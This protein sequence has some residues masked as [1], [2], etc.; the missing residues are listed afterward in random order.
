MKR[1]R[2]AVLSVAKHAY[3]PRGVASHPRFELVVVADDADQPA[4]V[5]QRNQQ[6]ADEC[7]IPYVRDVEAALANH[8]V[9]VAVVCSAVDRHGDLSARAASAG[10]HVVQDKPMSDRPEECDRVVEAVERNQV[11]FLLWN[12]NFLPAVLEARRA[13]L[14]G[15]IGQVRAMHVDFYFAKDAGPRKGSRR[16]HDPPINWLDHQIAA[17]ADGSDGGLCQSPLGELAIEGI[18]PLGYMRMLVPA[19]VQRVFARAAAHFH[20]VY[21]DNHVEDLATVTLEMEGGIVGSLCLGRI[22]AAS[23]PEIGEIKIRVLGTTGALVVGEPR[24][25]VAIHYRGQPPL[26][27]RRRRL[28]IDHDYLLMEDFAQAIDQDGPTILD[29]RAGRAIC[30]VVRAA[31]ESARTG[32]VVPAARGPA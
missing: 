15:A 17:H 32:R 14:A 13:V 3:V 28:D 31:L 23:H 26:E 21:A 16:P 25:E 6:F 29:A 8:G 7:G 22:G 18:Y 12:R 30:A 2:C 24:P 4:W 1:F 27:Y 10:V 20:Q 9:D 11:K 19:A 5:H